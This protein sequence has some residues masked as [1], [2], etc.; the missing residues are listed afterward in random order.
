MQPLTQGNI[1]LAATVMLLR[2]NREGLQV[3]MA[4]RPGK[5]VFPDIYVFPGGKV[6]ESDWAPEICF[7]LTDEEACQNMSLESG[8]HRYWVAAARECFEECGVLL[9]RRSEG[10]ANLL[11]DTEFA[12]ETS[13]RGR[14]LSDQVSFE[15]ICKEQNWLI[16]CES[17]AYFSHWITP[18][19][20]PKRFDTR[21]F[22]AAMPEEQSAIAHEEEIMDA[23]WIQPKSALENFRHDRWKMIDPTI[24]SLETLSQFDSVS[25]AL[26]GV[27][28]GQH[29]MAWTEELGQQ[30]MQK[31]VSTPVLQ[32]R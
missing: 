24:R 14:L 25:A 12:T 29:L 18:E 1:R 5:G 31:F 30:G 4:R 23:Q 2:D 27:R 20:A 21:F 32:K 6:D 3:Y 16:D 13:I 17:L 10:R 8:A 15:A 22:I 28:G 19:M 11:G 9:V 7:G 26:E